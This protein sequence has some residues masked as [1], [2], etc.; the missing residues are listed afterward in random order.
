M[1]VQAVPQE[2]LLP[3]ET[4]VLEALASVDIQWT[5]RQLAQRTGYS[6]GLVNTIL[7]KLSRTGYVKI[8]SI[9]KQR[10]QYLLT[11]QG[12]ATASKVACGYILRTFRD[13]QQLYGQISVFFRDL[14]SQGHQDL[15]VY[16]DNPELKTLLNVV[17]RDCGLADKIK[18]HDGDD[19]C[20]TKVYLKGA[21]MTAS[22]PQLNISVSGTTNGGGL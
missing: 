5:Q 9:N 1:T 17:M 11:P 7:K 8:T 12:I 20:T 21:A 14:S 19:Q 10:L 2:Q 22:G 4:T 3:S 15:C 16:Y 13:Y 18:I 6:I